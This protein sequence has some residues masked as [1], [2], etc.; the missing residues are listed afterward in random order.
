MEVIDPEGKR[1]LSL[2]EASTA[3]S[4]Q[5]NRAGFYELQLADG[6][7]D[8]IGVNADRRESDLSVIPDDTLALW[9]GNPGAGAQQASAGGQAQE[10]TKKPY[11]V[12]WYVMFFVLATAVAESVLADGYLGVQQEEP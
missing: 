7:H 12:W 3:Q 4:Y 6:R 8:L 1:P 11:S 9:R 2:K 5:L 10:Q